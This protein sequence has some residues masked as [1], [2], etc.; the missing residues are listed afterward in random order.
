MESEYSIADFEITSI[1]PPELEGLDAQTLFD[2]FDIAM[3]WGESGEFEVLKPPVFGEI[4]QGFL[5]AVCLTSPDTSLI[6]FKKSKLAQDFYLADEG[7]FTIKTKKIATVVWDIRISLEEAA[8]VIEELDETAREK[9]LIDPATGERIFARPAIGE[10]IY[11]VSEVFSNP[12]DILIFPSGFSDEFIFAQFDCS[13]L[14]RIYHAGSS[15]FACLK[16]S[17]EAIEQA[18]STFQEIM[19][20][21]RMTPISFL[22]LDEEKSKTV[23]GK[24]TAQ[25]N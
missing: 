8:S 10:R 6:L 18:L 2:L 21:E 15:K 16:S 9:G 25:F 5:I 19:M 23:A 17:A 7:V 24:N 12:N 4:E 3:N 11:K 20:T 14:V 1:L 22:I 13:E